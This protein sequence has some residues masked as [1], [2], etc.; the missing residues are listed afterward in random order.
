MTQ[1]AVK[2]AFL[3]VVAAH[4]SISWEQ[5]SSHFSAVLAPNASR[6]WVPTLWDM[7]RAIAAMQTIKASVGVDSIVYMNE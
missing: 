7:H 2:R 6:A 1:K 5:T 3:S 4:A